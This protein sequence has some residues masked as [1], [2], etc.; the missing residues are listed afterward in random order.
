M[1]T[2]Y[3]GE[4]HRGG[5]GGEVGNRWMLPE[6]AATQERRGRGELGLNPNTTPLIPYA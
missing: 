3:A 2:R 1:P 5:G 4:V 6:E